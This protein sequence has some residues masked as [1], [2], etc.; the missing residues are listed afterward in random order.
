L[1]SPSQ[2][3]KFVIF[4]KSVV[5]WEI[6][7]SQVLRMK[8]WIS[9]EGAFIRL[10]TLSEEREGKIILE[11]YLFFIAREKMCWEGRIVI[12]FSV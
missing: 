12:P 9:L 7:Y 5:P 11:F 6:M 8:T 2:T 10:V 3:L 1:T 4:A